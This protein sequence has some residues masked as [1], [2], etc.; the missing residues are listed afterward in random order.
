MTK[1]NRVLI[2]G[3]FGENNLGDELILA[4]IGDIVRK[5][6]PNAEISVMASNPRRVL[7]NHS[8][9]DFDGTIST[10]VDH[11]PISILRTFKYGALKVLK[12][13][14]NIDL[15]VMATGGALSDWNPTSTIAI[16]DLLD[17]W[18]QKGIPVVFSGVGADL[19]KEWNHMKS[20]GFH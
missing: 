11:R 6:A 9:K 15:V 3:W 2:Y 18:T 8:R 7:K 14:S 12:N 1:R 19:L 17:L 16:F 13:L 4:S 10:Y 20:L 5:V